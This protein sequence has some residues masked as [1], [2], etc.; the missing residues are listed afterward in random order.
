MAPKKT[1]TLPSRDALS[2]GLRLPSNDPTVF[3][4]LYK[5]SKPSLIQLATDWCSEEYRDTCGP[6]INQDYAPE[7]PDIPWAAANTIEELVELY[8]EE[9]TQRKG[10]KRELVDRILEGD[11][12]HGLSLHQLAMAECQSLLDHPTTH[13]WTAFRIALSPSS[14]PSST[15]TALPPI[16]APSF[17]LAL[18]HEIASLIKAHYH[19]TRPPNLPLTLIR[20]ALFDTPY[21]TT[22]LTPA[23]L[24][25]SKSIFLAFP[26]GAP[27]IYISLPTATLKALQADST[28]HSLPAFVVKAIPVA[29]SSP[30]TRYALLPTRLSAHS[31]SALLALRGATRE[32]GVNG[33][34]A[35]Y[36]DANST[37]NALDFT[38]TPIDQDDAMSLD[39]E[40]PG[41]RTLPLN[42]GPPPSKRHR[43]IAAARFGPSGA[44]GDGK[45][46]SRLD[47]T[48][49]DATE[50][51]SWGPR[52]RV[53]FAGAHVFAGIRALV[54]AGAIDGERMPAWM[55]GEAGVSVGVVRDGRLEGWEETV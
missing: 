9:R 18:H 8:D 46:L 40:A 6:Y 54:E 41:K 28:T 37:N 47:I 20:I 22:T 25:A 44:P 32:T 53:S 12:R 51:A 26:D 33:A 48:L 11:W 35:Q 24:S 29:L 16:H 1:L 50:S 31:L 55:T 13:R 23:L 36:A 52:V 39:S 30:Q 7:D 42:F 27:F 45:A 15:T 10:S 19:I 5:L 3:K 17:I 21:T 49:E 14:K 43:S 2:H 4:T 38:S 34:W